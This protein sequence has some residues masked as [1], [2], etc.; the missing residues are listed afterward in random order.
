MDETKGGNVARPEQIRPAK[1]HEPAKLRE[2]RGIR[3]I[4]HPDGNDAKL[5][6][7]TGDGDLISMTAGLGDISAIEEEIRSTAEIM[8]Y[9][10]AMKKDAG[11]AAFEEL[12]LTALRPADIAVVADKATG[13]RFLVMQ[14]TDRLPIVIRLSPETMETTLRRIGKSAK[15]IAN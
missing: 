12:F 5:T 14:F 1:E 3:S 11:A 4:V 9:R 6:L 13:D 8:Q 15:R 7:Y 2:L 10:Q